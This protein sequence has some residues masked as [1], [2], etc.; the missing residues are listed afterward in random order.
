MDAPIYEAGNIAWMLTST[1]LV[2]FMIP[3]V[4]YFYS[5]M[6]RQKNAL[7]LIIACVLSLVVVSMEVRIDAFNI[8]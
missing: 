6:A 5:G 2:W 4:G 1:A 7:S 3:G 8:N